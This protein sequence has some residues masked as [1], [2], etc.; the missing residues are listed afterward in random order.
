MS[1]AIPDIVLDPDFQSLIPPLA[2][3]ERDSLK[4]AI[5]QQ[6]CLE[7]LYVWRT[8]DGK[9][10]LLDGHNRYQ[11][12]TENNR[13][14]TVRNV[15]VSSREEAEVWIL[16][17]QLGRRNLTDDQRAALAAVLLESRSKANRAKQLQQ[18]REVK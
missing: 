15:L 9:R 10:L 3:Q 11:I 1:T 16:E 14:F 2:A 12:C 17:H 13:S 18:A 7:P 5:L 8:D 6:G 4:S